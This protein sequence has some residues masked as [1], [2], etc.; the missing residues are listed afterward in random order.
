MISDDY[1]QETRGHRKIRRHT[2]LPLSRVCGT[3][4]YIMF[5]TV[6]QVA[7]TLSEETCASD[8]SY[9]SLT[10]FHHVEESTALK[11]SNK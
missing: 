1:F 7:R 10:R 2:I 8:V 6:T 4:P 9:K 3:V 11:G 5:L